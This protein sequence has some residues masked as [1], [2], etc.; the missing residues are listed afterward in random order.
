MVAVKWLRVA[1]AGRKG[2]PLHDSVGRVCT[3]DTRPCTQE[4]QL[5]K[6]DD[7]PSTGTLAR[8][9]SSSL[10]EL[11][12]GHE[13][14]ENAKD[15][16][17]GGN[18]EQSEV[19]IADLVKVEVDKVRVRALMLHLVHDCTDLVDVRACQAHQSRSET[20]DRQMERKLQEQRIQWC[21]RHG[22]VCKMVPGF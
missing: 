21:A 1:R 12:A 11:F 5:T 17:D 18:D 7:D 19:D 10:L 20:E 4:E 22:V 14:R 16:L 13:E 9:L 15:P 2:I 6:T 8:V 3:R